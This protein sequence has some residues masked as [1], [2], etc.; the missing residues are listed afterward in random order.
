LERHHAT[1]FVDPAVSAPIEEMRRRW[2]PRMARMIDA[3]LTLIYPWEATDPT[4]I[5]AWVEAAGSGLSSFRCR[6]GAPRRYVTDQG[7]G[8]GYAVDDVDGGHARAR[9]LVASPDFSPG[10]IER[11]VTVVHP[12]TSPR[13]DEAWAHLQFHPLDLEFR[14]HDIAVT[15]WDGRRWATTTVVPLAG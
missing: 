8:C 2:D 3:H 14:V 7:I 15:A 12:R 6:V 11:H 4:M 1:L 10:D 13:G 9:S 5:T